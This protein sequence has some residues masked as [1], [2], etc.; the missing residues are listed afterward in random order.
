MTRQLS[1]ING[2]NAV[3][4][5]DSPQL[6]N[7]L[8]SLCTDANSMEK[9]VSELIASSE[10]LQTEN[11]ISVLDIKYHSLLSYIIDI[12]MITR[13]KVQGLSIANC[14]AKH[15]LVENRTVMEKVRPLEQKLRYRI[16]KLLQQS[17][18][19]NPNDP[20][21]LKPD[22]DNLENK[23]ESDQD[24][25]NSTGEVKKYI[26][27]QIASLNY[28]SDNQKKEKDLDEAKK[29]ALKKSSI[30]SELV[31]ESSDAPLEMTESFTRKRIQEERIRITKY[32]E[33]NFTR[34]NLTKKQKRSMGK[35]VMRQSEL[36]T[37]TNFGDIS[38]L[39]DNNKF[40]ENRKRKAKR[41]F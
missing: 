2:A 41:K 20:M 1:D 19:K 39:E 33:A 7:L 32:E 37:I 27:P 10:Q 36:D 40:R 15:R 18:N 12:V 16:D 17:M 8:Q 24:S 35:H 5:E 29:R 21:S 9:F 26:P 23:L 4:A 28:I 3:I 6:E 25:D 34:V 22:L 38:V 11:G 13:M 31:Q 30:I 14:S